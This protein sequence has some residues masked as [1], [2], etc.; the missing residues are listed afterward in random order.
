MVLT[1]FPDQTLNSGLSLCL[2]RE[3]M[4]MGQPT[5]HCRNQGFL[6]KAKGKHGGGESQRQQVP[7]VCTVWNLSPLVANVRRAVS[8]TWPGCDMGLHSP[9]DRNS[10]Q[11]VS[12]SNPR[13]HHFQMSHFTV[14][15][16]ETQEVGAKGSRS[17]DFLP[18]RRPFLAGC[19][20]PGV[21]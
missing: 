11:G 21:C 18:S 10:L 4:K 6:S 13:A 7:P 8:S 19:A 2:L 14:G 15:N 9:Q 16:M 17:H 3:G 5:G 12:L 20:Q 1:G